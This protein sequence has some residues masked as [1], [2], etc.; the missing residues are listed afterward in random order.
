MITA[1]ERWQNMIHYEQALYREGILLIAGIDEAGR[2]PLA[3]PVTAAAVILAEDSYIPGLNDSKQLTARQRAALE[4]QI[5]RSALAW[6]IADVDAATI[7]RINILQ[8]ARLAMAQ[9]VEQLAVTP[10]YLLTD[11]TTI[12]INLPQQAIIKGDTLSVSIAA[13][14]VLAKTH[15]DR[16]MAD[17][18]PVYPG[19]GF[20][21]HK[22]Y[23]TRQHKEALGRLGPCPIHRQNF[24][25]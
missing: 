22:G 11:A 24:R 20:A 13:A 12:D 1:A 16:L 18:E 8:A 9:A 23:G 5:K 19:Y 2:G 10:Q 17:Y 3:G 14:S 7:D 25:Y 4:E 21:Q 6:A 15:R